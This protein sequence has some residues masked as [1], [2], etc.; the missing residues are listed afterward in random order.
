MSRS[1]TAVR[2][3]S[4]CLLTLAQQSCASGTPDPAPGGE[5]P[6]IQGQLQRTTVRNL[7][8]EA[9]Q[10][11]QDGRGGRRPHAGISDTAR[12]GGPSRGALSLERLGVS[13]GFFDFFELGGDAGVDGADVCLDDATTA[14]DA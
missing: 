2:G 13:D 9:K 3:P 5:R 12:P 14:V 6:G 11:G 4:A 7:F 10:R 8:R 1:D